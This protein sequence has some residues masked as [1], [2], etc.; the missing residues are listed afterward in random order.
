MDETSL[1]LTFTEDRKTVKTILFEEDSTEFEYSSKG[2]AVG[3]IYIQKEAL[4]L[5]GNPVKIK[6]TIEPVKGEE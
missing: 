5:I 3:Y 1:N 2:Y 4:E 6:V